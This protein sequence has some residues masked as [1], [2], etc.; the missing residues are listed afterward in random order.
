MTSEGSPAEELRGARDAAGLRIAVL[1]GRFNSEITERLLLG[2]Q[3]A[4][5]EHGGRESDIEVVRV[6]G[7]WELPQTAA[8][9]VDSGRFDAVIA[10]GCVIRGDTPHFD[11][12]CE[13]ANLGLGEVARASDIPVVFGVLTTENAAQARARA[14]EGSD[15]KGHESALAA[16]EMVAVL[17]SLEAD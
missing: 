3:N 6:P 13:H 5:E 11:Y 17:H 15:N 8:R 10:L 7:A 12:V 2:A 1:V 16:L 9:A 14:G 4:L